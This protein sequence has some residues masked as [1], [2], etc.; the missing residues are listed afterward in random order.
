MFL[1][2]NTEYHVRDDICVAVRDRSSKRFLEGHMALS[3]KL[4]GGVKLHANGCAVPSLDAPTAGDAIYF[5]YKNR[6]G[7]E[8]QIVTSR[9]EAI[10]RPEKRVV[11][12]YPR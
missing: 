8:R 12:S 4:E 1:T 6:S 10:A 11:E 3:L 9:V 5:N 2:R 7:E